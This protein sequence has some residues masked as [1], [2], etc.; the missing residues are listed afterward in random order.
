MVDAYIERQLVACLNE[1]PLDQQ[2]QVLNFARQLQ[3]EA[4]VVVPGAAL[5]QFAGAID[6]DDLNKMSAAIEAGC[7][8]I[9]ADE[10]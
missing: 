9:D 2:R 1:M 7:E 10:W 5:L 8:R 3:G 6:G 4:L